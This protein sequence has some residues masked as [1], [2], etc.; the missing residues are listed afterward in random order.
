MKIKHIL[1]FYI[2][3]LSGSIFGQ[4]EQTGIKSQLIDQSG[5]PIIG[6]WISVNHAGPK[7]Q[8]DENGYFILNSVTWP[9]HLDVDLGDENIVHVDVVD[10]TAA[11]KITANK[12]VELKEVVIKEKVNREL[13]TLETRNVETIGKR[14]FQKAA[15]C[16]LSE[17][18]DNSGSVSVS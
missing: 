1:L 10:A 5:T 2:L 14:E 12:V 18:F 11:L 3:I 7:V 17:S 4:N 16:R 8:T 9:A 6:A 13:N 15:C